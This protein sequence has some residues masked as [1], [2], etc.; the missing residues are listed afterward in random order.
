MVTFE[1]LRWLTHHNLSVSM[2]DY[3][4]SLISTIMP[5]QPIRGDLRKAQ[6]EAYLDMKRRLVIARTFI[7]AKLERSGQ[8]LDWLKESHDVDK[9]IRRFKKEANNLTETKTVDHVRGVE[10]RAAEIYWQAFQKAVPL[11]LEFKTRSTRARN[12]QY[13]ASDPVNALLN[14]GYAFLQSYVRRGINMTGLDSSLG[15]LHE[16]KPAASPLVY[17]FEEPFRW[18]VDLTVLRLI[19]AGAFTRNDFYFTAEDYRL[20]IKPPL[21]DRYAGLLR[22]QF[23]AGVVY[24][25][26]R[27][28]WD[29]VILRKSQELARFLVGR[30]NRFELTAPRPALDRE[31]SR[32]LRDKIRSLTSSEAKK[33]GIG[34]STLHY[35]RINAKKNR[36]FKIYA[37]VRNKIEPVLEASPANFNDDD[38]TCARSVHAFSN[39]S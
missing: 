28:Q 9:E 32:A 34:K 10:G 38:S 3:D 16:D 6:V 21:L 14:Y 24:G 18:L 30:T 11:K 36:P 37:K 8:I 25:G 19:E 27:L 7:E 4:G 15:F 1:A 31:D 33:L 12:R 23:N 17:D 20:R 29:T 39:W 13:N 2:L 35:L 26:D 22:Q 5:P